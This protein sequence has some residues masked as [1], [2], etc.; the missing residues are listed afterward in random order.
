M[1]DILCTMM[2][3]GLLV[4]V[5]AQAVA[6]GGAGENEKLPLEGLRVAL[7]TGEGFQDQETL[8]PLA[9]LQNRGAEV[10]VVGPETGQVKAYNSDVHLIIR[11]AAADVSAADFDALVLPGGKA[12]AKIRENEHV[13]NLARGIVEAGKPVA[14]ICHGPQVLVTADVIKDRTMTAY[15][16]VADELRAAGANYRDQAMV[17]DQNLIT[18]RIP[19]DIPVWLAAMEEL[20]A[21]AANK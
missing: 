18:S 5:A 2:A 11:A 20:F 3:T 14:A 7:V 13:V 19:K 17:Q 4:A 6:N 9:F 8:M 15:A 10:T 21:T 16:D 12:P 1:Q